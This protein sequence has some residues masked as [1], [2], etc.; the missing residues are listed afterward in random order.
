MRFTH[1][2]SA[3]LLAGSAHAQFTYSELFINP[4]GADNGQEFVEIRGG[5]NA[6][7]TGYFMLVIDGDSPPAGTLDKVIDLG[8]FKTG[9]N[10]LLLIRDAN[11]TLN[12]APAAATSVVVRDFSPDIENGTNTYVLG[13]GT[14]PTQGTDLDMNNDGK[15]DNGIPN[16]TV[17]DAVAY[18]DG[19]S[20]DHM[21]A[22][23]LGG[24]E[25]P[26][27]EHTPDALIR[28]YSAS[29]DAFCW[30][31]CDVVAQTMTGPYDVDFASEEFRG[32][33]SKGFGPQA[34]SPGNTNASLSLCT[35]GFSVSVANG[36][37][38][39][40]TLDAGTANAG[41]TYLFLGSLAGT[42]PGIPLGNNVTVPLNLDIY[43]QILIGAPNAVIVPTIGVLDA[44]GQATAKFTLPAGG[45]LQAD[46]Q[47][48][49][50]AVVIDRTGAF[51]FAST[52]GTVFTRT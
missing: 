50:A 15:L 51:V 26:R 45:L 25:I 40:M 10:G 1:L 33:L 48:N 11:T 28:I 9:A 41:N 3:A 34:L 43:M 37:S 6:A 44:K 23:E 24:F 21:Y 27:S 8:S 31:D 47:I 17:V 12:P 52:P 13:R 29:G 18:T 38:Q 4:P 16:F 39:S 19:G 7:L 36:G 32:G 22:A 49:H 46:I 42:T 20:S 14:P 30:T 2:V 35:D 5:A